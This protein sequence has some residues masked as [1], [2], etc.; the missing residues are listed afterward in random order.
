MSA[1]IPYDVTVARIVEFTVTVY[2]VTA[3]EAKEEA[4]E[5][6]G[7]KFVITARPQE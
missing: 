3:E 6:E 5:I 7:V 1:R 4:A 2:A